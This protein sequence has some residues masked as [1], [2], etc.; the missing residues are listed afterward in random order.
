MVVEPLRKPAHVATRVRDAIHPVQFGIFPNRLTLSQ[1]HD[2]ISSGF[3]EDV[4]SVRDG[5]EMD[6]AYYLET[7]LSLLK[8]IQLHLS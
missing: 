1:P 2:E 8:L 4:S 6:P 3:E 5:V 7:P